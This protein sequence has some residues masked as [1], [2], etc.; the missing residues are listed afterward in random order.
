MDSC[1]AIGLGDPSRHILIRLVSVVVKIF[2]VLPRR[3]TAVDSA[4]FSSDNAVERY[5]EEL[6]GAVQEVLLSE[7]HVVQAVAQED[8]QS[9]TCESPL[10][11]WKIDLNLFGRFIQ[12]C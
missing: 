2:N 5:F 11:S 4:N 7:V 1:N 8:V 6:L 9:L 3:H 10:A 12:F